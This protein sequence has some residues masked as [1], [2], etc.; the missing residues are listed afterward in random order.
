MAKLPEDL[1]DEIK[2]QWFPEGD[3][4]DSD[5]SK[6]AK[7]QF[8]YKDVE[9]FDKW[10][11]DHS[12]SD[13][14]GFDDKASKEPSTKDILKKISGGRSGEDVL[15]NEADRFSDP[16]SEAGRFLRKY[17]DKIYNFESF[18]QAVKQAWDKDGESIK[19]LYENIRK[20]NLDEVLTPLFN[21]KEVQKWLMENN[22]S[23]IIQKIQ[24]KYKVEPRRARIIYE[25]L[26]P[27]SKE[28]LLKAVSQAQPKIRMVEQKPAQ[29]PQMALIR[30]VSKAGTRYTRVKPMR[31]TE[32]QILFL[33]ARRGLPLERVLETY[34][35][36][37]QNNRTLSSLRNKL[38]RTIS[39]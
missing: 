7:K 38:Y 27:Q 35:Q 16:T 14:K 37:F 36:T 22:E 25:R 17:K 5:R 23:N 1:H 8:S 32:N 18:K 30:Q 29:K 39:S 19:N 10:K 2:S 12:R 9:E 3:A 20:K 31:W 4:L 13:L 33:Q 28:R 11:K 24:K 26:S 21:T 34:N 15:Q 6:D